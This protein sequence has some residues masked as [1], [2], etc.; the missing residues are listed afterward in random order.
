MIIQG[1]RINE[2]NF[3]YVRKSYSYLLMI[4]VFL[5]QYVVKLIIIV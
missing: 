2:S 4:S 3:I 1:V 5:I